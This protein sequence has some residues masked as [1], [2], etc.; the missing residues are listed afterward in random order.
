[1]PLRTMVPAVRIPLAN[2]VETAVVLAQRGMLRP[3]R[4]DR[5][6]QI[7]IVLRR[8]GS[9]PAGAFAVNAIA[10]GD[11]LGIVD[12]ERALTYLE[13]DRRTNA[14]ANELAKHG[15]GPGQKLAV[16]ARN[17]AGFVESLVACAKA[18][19]DLLPLNTSFAAREFKA[20]IDR[21]RP[22]VIVYEPEF[23]DVV[24]EAAL[25][26]GVHVISGAGGSGAE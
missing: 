3:I 10:R 8:W 14:L 11:Q 4:P 2:R 15:L 19:A 23:E 21:E 25:D 13:I 12:D 6:L 9:T 7:G 18:G 22:P 24:R 16:L 20:V 5:L 1:M 17:G 26:V